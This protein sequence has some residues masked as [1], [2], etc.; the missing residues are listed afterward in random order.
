[1][2]EAQGYSQLSVLAKSYAN[3]GFLQSIKQQDIVSQKNLTTVFLISNK[4]GMIKK[5]FPIDQIRSLKSYHSLHINV[6]KGDI[7]KKTIDLVTCPG[8]IYLVGNK[9][10]IN[11]D[12]QV[13]R[14]W[15]NNLYTELL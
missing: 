3:P 2:Q 4:D 5:D 11:R 9:E 14:A 8:F 15:E 10:D 6:K 13:I 1:M 7:L 12:I